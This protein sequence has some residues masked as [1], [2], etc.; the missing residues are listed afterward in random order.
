[1]SHFMPR[2]ISATLK[3]R[4]SPLLLASLLAVGATSAFA[5]TP[6]PA[7]D[8]AP[9]AQRGMRHDMREGAPQ[10]GRDGTM[11]PERMQQHMARRHADLKV[12]LKIEPSQEAA[13]TTFTEAMKPPADMQQ[14]RKQIREEMQKLT[15]PERIDRMRAL[16]TERQAVMDKRGEAVK[17][18]YAT[19][20]PEQKKTF[21]SFPMMGEGGAHGGQGGHHGHGMKHH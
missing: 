2:S 7:P 6:P 20:N 21:D 13:W 19:L 16:R 14:R 9:K 8:G 1:M 3:N 4:L 11:S 15:S 12:K 18:F 17:A 5:Q 10:A